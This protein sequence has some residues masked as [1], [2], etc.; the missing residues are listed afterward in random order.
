M[1][2][3]LLKGSEQR[4]S[5]SWEIGSKHGQSWGGGHGGAHHTHQ[6][7]TKKEVVKSESWWNS[8]VCLATTSQKC[9][10]KQLASNGLHLSLLTFK[11]VS[12]ACVV[13]IGSIFVTWTINLIAR[14]RKLCDTRLCT[15]TWKRQ[16]TIADTW[17]MLFRGGAKRWNCQKRRID[18][19]LQALS[20]FDST[21]VPMKLLG[22]RRWIILVLC[23]KPL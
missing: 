21:V 9:C 12:C 18:S 23:S 15:Q 7:S 8:G 1:V 10:W 6:N 17:E 19:L 4:R 16:K 3:T 20:T 13:N 11:I 22:V 14:A 2:G 5:E